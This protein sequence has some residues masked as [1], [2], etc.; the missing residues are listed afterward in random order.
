MDL[1]DKDFQELVARGKSQG[2][3]T[4]DEVNDYLPDE[5]VNPDKLDN[6]LIALE[7]EGIDLLNEPPAPEFYD[8][9]EASETAEA[10]AEYL[11]KGEAPAGPADPPPLAGEVTKFS[12]DPIRMY[13]SQMAAIPLL[14]RSEEIA[15][16]KKIEVTRK[17]FRR[18]VIGCA[19]AMRAT[20]GTLVKVH[21]GALPFDRTIKVS[22]TERLTKEQIIA[23][24]PHNLSTL[25][26]LME[27][28]QKDFNVLLNRRTEL[29]VRQ[30]ARQRF[31]RRRRKMLTLIEELSLRTR[32]VQVMMR[33]MEDCAGADG[34]NPPPASA[35][36]GQP[37]HAR[38]AGEPAPRTPRPDGPDP[39]EP[40]KPPPPL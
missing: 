24:M 19:V 2:Y 17:R 38:Q 27:E 23:R 11:A 7:E 18:T 8:A 36:A 34:R 26:H 3:L 12:S 31:I 40:Q 33:Q 30:E 6:L 13:L 9:A 14:A 29:A 32:R 1:F 15:L 28:N 16:A 35:A 25:S 21:K 22:L 5:E 4:Y 20:V 37:G 39:G 10:S